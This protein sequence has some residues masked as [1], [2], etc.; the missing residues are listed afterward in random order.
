MQN[1]NL[2]TGGEVVCPKAR[3]N[4]LITRELP[5]EELVYDLDAR[6]AHC[7]N[8]S[9]ALIWKQCDGQ[10]TIEEIAARL[11]LELGTVVNVAFVN[12]ALEQL[13]K[14]NL[15]EQ[16]IAPIAANARQQRRELLR[17]MGLGA[18]A[19]L[20]LVTTVIAP[21]SIQAMTCRPPNS[22]G[23]PNGCP[24]TGAAACTSGC[25]GF[26]ASA[27]NMCVT[28]GTVLPNSSCR[29]GCECASGSCVNPPGPGGLVCAPMSP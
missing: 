8:Q 4:K 27:G 16:P 15:L 7:L 3:N 20:P 24:C 2:Q 14:A 21:L 5:D 11:Q 6:Q 26:S 25:C 23:N 13:S 1:Q 12:L 29:A 9:A 28:P 22:A 10:Q 18:A 17:R 19:A